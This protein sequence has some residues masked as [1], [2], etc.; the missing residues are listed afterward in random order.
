MQFIVVGEQ[1]WGNTKYSTSSVSKN[2]I[3]FSDINFI[4]QYIILIEINNFQK[5]LLVKD[6]HPIR[7]NARHHNWM[8]IGLRTVSG[9]SFLLPLN[10]HFDKQDKEISTVSY[11]VGY[12]QVT[13]SFNL[14]TININWSIRIWIIVQ[15]KS[16]VGN[17]ANLFSRVRSYTVTFL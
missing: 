7:R 9:S 16:S 5:E 3:F 6:F 2:E 14:I 8:K 17:F 15:Q 13:S 4:K 11:N 12:S 10:L 1:F